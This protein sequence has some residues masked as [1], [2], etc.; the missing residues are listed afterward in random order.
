MNASTAC[1]TKRVASTGVE[2][3]YGPACHGRLAAV[4]PDVGLH[5]AAV[6][7]VDGAEACDGASVEPGVSDVEL[8]PLR[9]L[10]SRLAHRRRASAIACAIVPASATEKVATTVPGRLTITTAGS[11]RTPVFAI[12]P[13]IAVSFR[14]LRGTNAARPRCAAARASLR[15]SASTAAP[16]I[17]TLTTTTR[18]Y[19][20]A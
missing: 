12:K 3:A 1:V 11:G 4:G 7:L 20:N 8:A 13:D 10:K 16:G 18:L 17:E 6:T 2:N 9:G 14:A 15:T 19:R 5:D